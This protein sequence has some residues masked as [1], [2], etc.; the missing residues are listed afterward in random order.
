MKRMS[1]YALKQ[2]PAS[3]KVWFTSLFA[4]LCLLPNLRA[5]EVLFSINGESDVQRISTTDAEAKLVTGI[6]KRL[7]VVTGHQEPWPGIRLAAP[8]GRWD[9]SAFAQV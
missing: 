7:H 3:A 4:L 8:A 9:L 6:N 1:S 5:D 2:L